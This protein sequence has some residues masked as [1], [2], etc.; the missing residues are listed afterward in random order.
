MKPWKRF[1]HTI[2]QLWRTRGGKAQRTTSGRQ[3]QENL[4]DIEA[5]YGDISFLIEC[6]QKASKIVRAQGREQKSIRVPINWFDQVD[7]AHGQGIRMVVTA[8]YGIPGA[9]IVMMKWDQFW[10]LMTKATHLE[11]SPGYDENDTQLIEGLAEIEHDQ[12]QAWSKE[13]ARNEIISE[14]RRKRWAECW[15]PY[16]E[17][18][19]DIKEFDREW[20]RQVLKILKGGE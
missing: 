18:A 2:T 11:Y 20:A 15:I 16:D 3:G 5:E 4:P 9:Q 13:L 19:D 10:A 12:W 7:Q 6:K 14:H 8:Y 1:E 17:L